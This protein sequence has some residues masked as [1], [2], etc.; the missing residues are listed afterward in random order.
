MKIL[1]ANIFVMDD[2]E[3]VLKSSSSNSPCFTILAVS[4]LI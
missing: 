2:C 3:E 4:V 1:P